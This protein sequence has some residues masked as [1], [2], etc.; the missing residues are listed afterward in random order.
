MC[1]F[2]FY[3][4]V[5]GRGENH[6]KEG[7]EWFG[8]SPMTRP[9]LHKN[10]AHA[11]KRTLVFLFF[12]MLCIILSHSVDGSGASSEARVRFPLVVDP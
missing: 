12:F 9:S 3:K 11:A 2:I 1:F 4:L 8:F 6:T 7:K 5:H 10:H